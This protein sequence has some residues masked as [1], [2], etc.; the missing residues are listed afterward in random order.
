MVPASS[1]TVSVGVNLGVGHKELLCLGCHGNIYKSLGTRKGRYTYLYREYVRASEAD[2]PAARRAVLEF[3]TK[4]HTSDIV[5]DKHGTC[6]VR[7]GG[8]GDNEPYASVQDGTGVETRRVSPPDIPVNPPKSK[9]RKRGRKVNYVTVKRERVGEE[10]VTV[11]RER[12]GGEYQD[13]V[14]TD[15]VSPPQHKR[16]RGRKA[17]YLTV[18]AFQQYQDEMNASMAGMASDLK[19]IVKEVEGLEH[20]IKRLADI[21]VIDVADT[22]HLYEAKDGPV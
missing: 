8:E 3:V 5:T 22:V 11:K 7:E 13:K 16:K 4:W 10:N 15:S 18:E 9:R 21:S 1:S 6:P 14:E 2:R 20:S 19:E 12:E 17:E